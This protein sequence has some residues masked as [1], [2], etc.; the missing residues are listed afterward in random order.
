MAAK[1]PAPTMA[2]TNFNPWKETLTPEFIAE[3]KFITLSCG[4]CPANGVTCNK[5]DTTCRGNF[6]NWA[7][8]EY[9]QEEPAGGV[10]D[11]DS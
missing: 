6:L 4:A 7:R 2:Q 9:E 3:G 11:A 5:Y 1:K 8:R 10:I